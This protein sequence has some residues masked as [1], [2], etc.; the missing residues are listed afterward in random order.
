MLDDVVSIRDF[1]RYEFDFNQSTPSNYII[2]YI[3]VIPHQDSSNNLIIWLDKNNVKPYFTL[4]Q[5]DDLRIPNTEIEPSDFYEEKFSGDLR[6]GYVEDVRIRAR[7][8]NRTN[9][10]LGS[11]I[12]TGWYY[13]DG[14]E[15]YVYARPIQQSF[16]NSGATPNYS[17]RLSTPARQGAPIIMEISEYPENVLTRTNFVDENDRSLNSFYNIEYIE[18]RNSNNL[19]LG[20]KNVYD[21]SVFDPIANSFVVQNKFS[22]T[23]RIAV[24]NHATP[25]ILE[26]G[27]EYKVKYRVR[28]SFYVDNEDYN[29]GV[30]GTKIYFDS[31]PMYGATPLQGPF[32]YNVTYESS[33]FDTATP[34]GLYHS[35]IVSLNSEHFVY[36]TNSNYEYDRFIAQM[37]PAVISDNKNSDYA[38]LTIESLD[39]NLNPKP[40]QT[41]SI[42][43]SNLSATPSTVTTNNEGFAVVELRYNG[44]YPATVSYDKVLISGIVSGE[45]VA[46]DN[47]TINY[48]IVRSAQSTNRLIAETSQQTV[49]ADGQSSVYI[50]GKIVSQDSTVDNVR[51][52]YRTARTLKDAFDVSYTS[53]VVTSQNGSFSIGPI[54]SQSAATPGYWFMVVDSVMQDASVTNS[55]P[56]TIVGDIVHWYEDA[57]DVITSSSIRVYPVQDSFTSDQLK[58]FYAT[59]VYKVSYITGDESTPSAKNTLNI[60]YWVK[61]PR[62]VQYQAGILGDDYYQY[63]NENNTYPS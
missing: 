49:R 39:K 18:A 57:D 26:E 58:Y 45:S 33:I 52:Y 43:S 25:V 27:R 24:S 34:T 19:Y 62:Y 30:I 61:V 14:E 17:F 8:D 59:P 55:N 51:V 5:D 56:Q 22:E 48:Q 40:Y 3:D 9:P 63:K 29:N 15:T 44:T 2:N 11:E 37:N 7:L 28:N 23:E 1:H 32:T 35:P 13:L 46:T 12:H 21:V 16:V 60:P 38:L 31:T 42:S 54:T 47:A 41:Y 36:L 50:T 20:Y 6:D 4:S 10:D 53:S